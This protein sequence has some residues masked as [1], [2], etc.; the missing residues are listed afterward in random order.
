MAPGASA[1][2]GGQLVPRAVESFSDKRTDG[3]QFAAKISK[4]RENLS[5]LIKFSN[6]F[7][8]DVLFSPKSAFFEFESSP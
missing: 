2:G 1:G 4:K 3:R 7:I 8:D 6:F 5:N